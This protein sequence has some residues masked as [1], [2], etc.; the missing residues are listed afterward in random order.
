MKLIYHLPSGNNIIRSPFDIA[1]N[2]MIKDKIIKIA[3]PYIGLNYFENVIIAGCKDW[4]L[5]TD[6]NALISS[7][8]NKNMIE[9]TVRFLER[10][11]KKIQHLD[12]LHSKVIISEGS[13]LIGSAN[14]TNNGITENN[15]M[16]IIISDFYKIQELNKWYNT[17][18]Q[19]AVELKADIFI[20][21]RNQIKNIEY[22]K[23]D[24]HYISS[25]KLI[26][27]NYE[28]IN[29]KNRINEQKDEEYL[30]NFLKHWNNKVFT[31]YFFDLAQYIIEKYNINEN[32][33][34]LCI[35]F[36]EER[37]K[38][39][40]TIGQRYVLAPYWFNES[41][42]L[43]M[44]LEYHKENAKFDGCYKEK[45]FKIKQKNNACWV[46]YKKESEIKLNNTTIAE[47]EKAI[48]NELN[49]SKKS[50]YRKYHQ[51]ILYKFIKDHEYR[52]KILEE[53]Y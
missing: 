26:K 27:T 49:R 19:Y 18:W 5:L 15:E 45:P 17:W 12:G 33:E 35:T 44:P 41:I 50:S 34:R 20:D 13:A 37:Y 38:I 4:E 23:N 36:R 14:F 31:E 22:V 10:F 16:S 40:V 52:N 43:I 46:Y 3:C 48:N 11:H 47:W 7:Q 51:F 28:Q 25:S 9:K 8:Q 30:I 6:I 42:G 1:I 2:E 39:P 21:L 32:D 29:I 53:I 24:I